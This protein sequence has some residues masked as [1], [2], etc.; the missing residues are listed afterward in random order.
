MLPEQKRW[1]RRMVCVAFLCFERTSF[2]KIR[3]FFFFPRRMQVGSQTCSLLCRAELPLTCVGLCQL[4]SLRNWDLLYN[5][6]KG[7]PHFKIVKHMQIVVI[8]T[9]RFLVVL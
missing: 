5:T 1:S 7:I 8:C 6:S 3:K 4:N 2:K 9:Y